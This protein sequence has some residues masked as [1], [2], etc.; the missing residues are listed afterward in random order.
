MVS[1]SLQLFLMVGKGLMAHFSP[2]NDVMVYGP[3]PSGYGETI[4][5]TCMCIIGR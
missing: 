2:P 3:L 1:A 4:T 5:H